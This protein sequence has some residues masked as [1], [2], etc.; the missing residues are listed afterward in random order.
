MSIAIATVS[1]A[2]VSRVD[3]YT[4]VDAPMVSPRSATYNNLNPLDADFCQ[5]QSARIMKKAGKIAPS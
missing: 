2:P 5:R 1:S 4:L 3:W